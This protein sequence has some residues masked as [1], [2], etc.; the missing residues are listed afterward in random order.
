MRNVGWQPRSLRLMGYIIVHLFHDLD[1]IAKIR[2]ENLRELFA[3]SKNK[4]T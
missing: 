3:L 4:E 1:N 2:E